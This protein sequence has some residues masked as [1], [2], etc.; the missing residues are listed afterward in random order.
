MMSEYLFARFRR[1][2]VVL[3]LFER[4]P[5]LLVV[6]LALLVMP[7]WAQAQ[8]VGPVLPLSEVLSRAE[9]YSPRLKSATA[10]VSA[11]HGSEVQARLLP[12][13]S[14]SLESENFAGTGSFGGFR[15]SETT[16]SASQLIELGGKRDARQAIAAAARRTAEVDVGAARLDLVRD[17]TLAY[18]DAVAAT[19]TLRLARDLETTAKRVF[20][21]VSR[22][23]GAARDPLYQRSRAEVAYTAATIARQR[24]EDAERAARKKLASYWGAD[25]LSERLDS[26]VLFERPAP[27]D[28]PAYQARLRETPELVRLDRIREARSAELR[29]AEAGAVPDVTVSAGVR[30]LQ[31]SSDTAFIAGVSLP[32]PVF[33]QNQG[34]IARTSAEVVRAARER[35]QAERERTRELIEAWAQWNSSWSEADQLN[36]RSIP[37]AERA[38]AQVLAGYRAGA[39]Q[40]LDVL[41]IQRTL[42]ETRTAHIAA[43]ARLQTA[44]ATVERLTAAT[45]PAQPETSP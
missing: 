19:E 18:V 38:F 9:A 26:G 31:G 15:G 44:R 24:A 13:P 22:R 29:L 23:V 2:L 12:N 40:Y 5:W 7:L 3:N 1:G 21:D 32:I 41:D 20:D 28:L 35:E 42:F 10:G 6:G 4:S 8:N 25:T 43:L 27:S 36:T 33:N 16:L 30:R 17:V 11:A 34:E 14:A 45:P 39:F 37:Q